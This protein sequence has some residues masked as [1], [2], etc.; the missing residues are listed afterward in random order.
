MS[1]KLVPYTNNGTTLQNIYVFDDLRLGTPR[2]K[3]SVF[4]SFVLYSIVAKMIPCF[5]M[6]IFGAL[7]LKTL[8]NHGRV[9]RKKLSKLGVVMNRPHTSRTTIMLLIVMVLFL[10]TELPQGILLILSLTIED[11]FDRVYIPLGDTMDILALINNSINFV[12]YCS[13][14]IEF[15]RTI[16]KWIC[17]CAKGNLFINENQND[18]EMKNQNSIE[19]KKSGNV[20]S[21]GNTTTDDMQTG[22]QLTGSG[23]SYSTTEINSPCCKS[24][25]DVHINGDIGYSPVSTEAEESEKLSPELNDDD[26][27]SDSESVLLSPSCAPSG[28]CTV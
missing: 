13:M 20:I 25:S 11:F 23:E 17:Q 2:V 16:S 10:V 18:F 1:S 28:P 4:S 21:I 15:R 14:S 24:I 19:T 8:D 3:I 6:I 27:V 12:L 7:L 22:L 26:D 5:L 9:T